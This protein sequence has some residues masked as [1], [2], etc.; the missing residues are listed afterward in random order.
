MSTLAAP[1]VRDP[2]G[3][4]LDEADRVLVVGG[5]AVAL[6]AARAVGI[7]GRVVVVCSGEGDRVAVDRARR[8]AGYYQVEAVLAARSLPAGDGTLDAVVLDRPGA[9]SLPRG[10]LISE[11]RRVLRPGGRVLVAGGDAGGRGP[12]IPPYVVDLPE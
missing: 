7:S 12:E 10:A 1:P 9:L 2:L 6:A 5:T 4:H 8:R 3:G 11:L